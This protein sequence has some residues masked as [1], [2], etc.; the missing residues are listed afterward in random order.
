MFSED[1]RTFHHCSL[2]FPWGFHIFL[3]QFI[4]FPASFQGAWHLGSG[5]D[6]GCQV[7]VGHFAQETVLE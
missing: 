1:F 3:Q 5:A 7:Q 4:P 2:I 6:R